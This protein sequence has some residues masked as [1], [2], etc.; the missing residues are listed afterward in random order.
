MR[1][2]SFS[3]LAALSVL[4]AA[5]TAAA[6][7]AAGDRLL[8]VRD[9]KYETGYDKFFASLQG[10]SHSGAAVFKVVSAAC[11]RHTSTV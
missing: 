10:G 5:S 8:V 11:K 4:L 3:P 1:A 2:T 6:R 9:K 7:S